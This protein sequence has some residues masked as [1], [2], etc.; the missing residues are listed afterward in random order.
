MILKISALA[1]LI[2]SI[3]IQADA[4]RLARGSG[5]TGGGFVVE[6]PETP[7]S[8]KYVSLLDL[9]EIRNLG[10]TLVE[11]TG[12]IQQDYYESVNRTYTLQGQPHLAEKNKQDIDR[13]LKNFFLHTKFV[14]DV[15]ELPTAHDIGS[16]PYIPS[17]C[18]I[19]Q[20]AFMNDESN[21]IHIL[22]PL[23]DQLNS[24]DQS[25]L[26]RHE[27]A[28]K[29]MRKNGQVTSVVSRNW[30][31]H[32]YVELDQVKKIDDQ[33]V[34]KDS[35]YG[36]SPYIQNRTNTNFYAQ[37]MYPGPILRLQFSELFGRAILA[38]TW[39]DIPNVEIKLKMKMLTDEEY[40]VWNGTNAPN[41]EC[42]LTTPNIDSKT[43][44]PIEGSMANEGTIEIKMK[45]GEPVQLTLFEN[46]KLISTNI[47]STCE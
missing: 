31:G 32:S 1:T 7:V 19:K 45:T 3:S 28:G 6:C 46:G 39:V 12:D 17:Q 5:S 22:K 38:K 35:Y 8:D 2:L 30:V 18:S 44:V 26:A 9:Y 27:I 43:T 47:I 15:S 25:A 4:S 16:K 21:T 41:W 36:Y 34:K 24:R 40:P 10:F 20:I 33:L 42:L 11:P 14:N 37:K 23:W 13:N 29:V